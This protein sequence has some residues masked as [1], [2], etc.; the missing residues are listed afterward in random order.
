MSYGLPLSTDVIQAISKK[1]VIEKFSLSGKERSRFDSAVH[2]ITICNEISPRTVNLPSGEDVRS[3]FVLRVEV[4]D[5]DFDRGSVSLLYKLIPQKMVLIAECGPRC[6]PLVFM[7]ML[8][9]GEWTLTD[10]LRLR[11]DGMDLDEVWENLVI[12][13]G[14][15]RIEGGNTLCQQISIDES[16]RRNVAEIERLERAMASEKQ[17][18]RKRELY[19]RIK[20]LR[21]RRRVFFHRHLSNP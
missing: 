1:A 17:P 21:G 5:E 18:R 3:I 8:I 16:R 2:R 14:G 15:I 6:R 9:V 7:D 11:L 10:E 20:V 19:E 12:G 4:H 13:I